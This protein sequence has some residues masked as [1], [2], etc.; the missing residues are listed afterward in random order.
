MANL[1]GAFTGGYP[2]TGGFARSVVNFD[3][4]AETP[5]AGAF[6]AMGLLMASLFADAAALFPAARRRWPRPSSWRSC[7]WSISRS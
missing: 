6:T 4:G 1:G 2:V 7:R 5:A 3:A